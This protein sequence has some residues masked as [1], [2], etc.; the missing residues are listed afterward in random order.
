[1]SNPILTEFF[2]P[3][4][5]YTRLQAALDQGKAPGP[6]RSGGGP[7]CPCGRRPPPGHRPPPGAGGPRRR[8]R[9]GGWP[10][11]WECSPAERS[12]CSPAGTFSSTPAPPPASGSTSGWRCW[13]GSAGW[14]ARCWWPPSRACSSEPCPLTFSPTPAGSCAWGGGL[15][16]GGPTDFLVRAG[17]TRCDQVEGVGQ[18]ALR[19]AFWTSSL[20]AWTSP[21]AWSS[22]GMRLTP[23]GSSTPSP[24]GGPPSG[25]P[26]PSSPPGRC[27]PKGAELLGP[28]PGPAHGLRPGIH[29]GGLPAPGRPVG[30][31]D[32]PKGGRA[33]QKHLWQLGGGRD[34]SA[35]TGAAH[36]QESRVCPDL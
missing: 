11:T 28:R 30:L 29:P 16:A 34:R 22:G 6:V 17:Y 15:P 5:D 23:W 31:C 19:G 13:P 33:G 24:S 2:I 25:R 10:G 12:P 20:P 18:F 27:S 8:G 9:P 14:T 36:R 26:A 21:S 3:P 7:S 1:M 4:G 32:T 35:G